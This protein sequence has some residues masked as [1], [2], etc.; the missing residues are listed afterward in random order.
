MMGKISK[1]RSFNKCVKYILDKSKDTRLLD[2]QGVRLKS[3]GSI[4][5]SFIAQAKLNPKLAISVCHISLSFTAQDRDKLSNEFLVKVARE[6]MQKMGITNTQYIVA[7]HFDKEHPHIHLCF[8]RVDNMGKTISD[9]NDR[10]RSVKICRE[11]T[12]KYGLYIA[13]GKEKVKEH[14][15]KEPDKTK[16]E[17]Y[18]AIK[19]AMPQCKNWEQLSDKLNKQGIDIKYK[20]KGQTDEVQGVIFSKNDYSF[21]GSKVDRMFSYSKIDA[22]LRENSISVNKAQQQSNP[23]E[24]NQEQSV[25]VV[26]SILDGLSGMSVFQSHGNDYEDELFKKRMSYEEKKRKQKNK[27]RRGL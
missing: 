5:Q 16:Y 9:K 22:Q 20:Y 26:G 4:V 1:G 6:Y 3:I 17:I 2:V 13:K 21:N 12:E 25:G 18:N 23:N 27:F 10:H 15:L 14:R 8:N 7:Q 24:I 11:L 19:N